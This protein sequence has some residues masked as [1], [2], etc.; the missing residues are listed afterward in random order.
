MPKYALIN[1]VQ[2][3]GGKL[4]AGSTIDGD[5]EAAQYAQALDAGGQLIELPNEAI[6]AAQAVALKLQRRGATDAE[7]TAIM[8]AAQAKL[9]GDGGGGLPPL[10]IVNN[11]P[12]DFIFEKAAYVELGYTAVDVDVIGPGGAGGSGRRGALGTFRYGGQGGGGGGRSRNRMLLADLPD[13]VFCH[14]GAG[15][16][17]APP[18]VN[19]D[20]DG[21]GGGGDGMPYSYFYYGG[22]YCV[23]AYAG[24][25]GRGGRSVL[26]P[27]FPHGGGGDLAG[28]SGGYTT[29][30]A[31]IYG[32]LIRYGYTPTI[33]MGFE[34]GLAQFGY[35]DQYAAGGGGGGGGI[36]DTE[37]Q[38]GGRPGAPAASGFMVGG[39]AP[40]GA[41]GN[42]GGNG[43]DADI[44][45]SP[46]A[47]FAQGGGGGGGGGC[48]PGDNAGA[49]GVGA[50][51]GGGGG[52]GG[53]STNDLGDGGA[54]GN[55]AGGIVNLWLS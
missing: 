51:Y 38:G 33:T 32:G 14:V 5:L 8:T 17:G 23:L 25:P 11:V 26:A 7:L 46:G 12:G 13:T 28:T 42:P 19:N 39:R 43:Q 21:N 37:G 18:N 41:N 1:T 4:V 27:E 9:G 15:G 55:G 20:S 35:I 24:A 44:V 50:N 29:D 36:N 48:S 10:R 40:G 16:V 31:D 22:A 6:E 30:A 53:G 52:G 2:L 47:N 3:A 54:G 49:G 34:N 45:T